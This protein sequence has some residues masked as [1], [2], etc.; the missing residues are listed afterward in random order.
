[1]GLTPSGIHRAYLMDP[2]RIDLAAKRGPSTAAACQLC[3]GVAAV[4][5]VKLLLGRGDAKPAPWHHHFDAYAGRY[6]QSRMTRGNAGRK[7]R[8]R[9]AVAK[10]VMARR[11]SASSSGPS[12]HRLRSGGHAGRG[13]GA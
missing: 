6:I 12:A 1:M 5:A 2:S 8:L 13:L 11:I 7:Q 9:L 3:S 4:S 10:R